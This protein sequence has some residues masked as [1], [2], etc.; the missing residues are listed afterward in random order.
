MSLACLCFDRW[1]VRTIKA[2]STS[3][4]VSCTVLVRLPL[5]VEFFMAEAGA[6]LCYRPS[7]PSDILRS[8]A[9]THL[10]FMNH[11][12]TPSQLLCL[13]IITSKRL[14]AKWKPIYEHRIWLAMVSGSHRWWGDSNEI[15]LRLPYFALWFSPPYLKLLKPG[16][17][18]KTL[19]R[20]LVVNSVLYR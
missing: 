11:I 16:V 5:F 18:C 10:T 7:A 3:I 2:C 9:V 17:T 4:L 20:F 15:K 6:F 1:I 19:E 12:C 8:E 14:L 13:I